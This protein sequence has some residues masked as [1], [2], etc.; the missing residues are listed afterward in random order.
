MKEYIK[1]ENG[2]I[3]YEIKSKTGKECYELMYIGNNKWECDY[4]TVDKKI[5]KTTNWLIKNCALEN[6]DFF[7]PKL[8][9]IYLKK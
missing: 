8:K 7:N 4:Y 6:R 3:V 1:I 9:P 2:L 5:I